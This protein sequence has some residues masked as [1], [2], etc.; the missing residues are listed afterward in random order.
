MSPSPNASDPITRPVPQTRLSALV[1]V[2][3]ETFKRWLAVLIALVA[4]LVAIAAFLQTRASNLA[5]VYGRESQRK[6]LQATGE[7]TRGQQQYGFDQYSVINL[8]DELYSQAIEAGASAQPRTPLSQAYLDAMNEPTL[9]ELSPLL[10]GD[11]VQ[12]DE[13]GYRSVTDYG[14]YQAETYVFTS[15]LLS[16][17]R[18]AYA[19]TA[20]EWGGKSDYFI[21]LIAILAVSLFLFGMAGTLSNALIRLLFVAVGLFITVL[22]AF[23]ILSTQLIPV[24]QVPEEALFQFARGAGS[25]HQATR[26]HN[27]STVEWRKHQQE[28]YQKAREAYTAALKLDPAYANAYAARGYIYM[29]IAPRDPDAAV[30]DFKRAIANG[31]R[32]YTTYW[33]YG[34]ALYLQ[35]D[36]P[37]VKKP[38]DLALQ[39]NEDICGPA[40]NTAVAALA[41]GELKAAA[42]EYDNSIKRCQQ[43]FDLAKRKGMDVPDSLWN[44]MQGAVDDLDNLLCVLAQPDDCYDGR[45]RPKLSLTN[46]SEVVAEAKNWRLRIKEALASLEFHSTTII[47]PNSGQWEPLTFACGR[48]DKD[49]NYLR[50][51]DNI[52]N[53]ANRNLSAPPILAVWKYKGMSPA[54]KLHWKIF[55]DGDEQTRLRF[56]EDWSLQE[57]GTA[58]RK[59]NSWYVLSDGLYEVEVYGN[60]KLLSNGKFR[61]ATTPAIRPALP[62]QVDSLAF[63]DTMDNNCARWSLADGAMQDGALEL[64]THEQDNSAQALCGYCYKVDDFYLEADTRYLAGAADNGYGLVYRKSNETNDFY[65]FS[66]SANGSFTVVRHAE[67]YC[68]AAQTKRWCDVIPWTASNWITQRGSNKLGVACRASTCDFYINDHLVDT[69]SDDALATGYYGVSVGTTDL[70]VAFDNVRV[71]NLR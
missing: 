18:E 2:P 14:R 22:A 48:L 6:A 17:Q 50:T 38:S 49:G 58:I 55:A 54:I 57:S 42:Q 24:H 62:I 70:K 64:V 23:G 1:Q 35:G 27:A 13:N 41:L 15:T 53:F 30:A 5:S 39:L 31:K 63:D 21:A 71:W 20:A 44:E 12:A 56:E 33:N 29:N 7:Q 34:F 43:V 69:A 3:D 45:D 46:T 60:G 16:E 68:D 25:E 52:T 36:Y 40:F 11:Y 28:F 32:D 67:N 59:L 47:P 26:Y 4:L 65:M 51:A 10:S 8:R 19:Y 66:I 61:I 37:A 9:R